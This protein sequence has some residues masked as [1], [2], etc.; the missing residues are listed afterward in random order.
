M[1]YIFFRTIPFRILDQQLSLL[2][3]YLCALF[4]FSC[5]WFSLPSS[6]LLQV[7]RHYHGHLSACYGMALHPT[8]DVLITC[9][10]DSTARV[11]DMRT[12][13]NIH[14]LA[15][16]QATVESV[17]SQAA[18]PQVSDSVESSVAMD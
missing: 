13:A 16:H 11:W 6:S 14:T 7:I 5:I 12:T 8:L 2:T 1:F 4:S 15:G 10:R 3:I 18:D 9:G 17:V